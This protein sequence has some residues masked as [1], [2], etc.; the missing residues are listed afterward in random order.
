[1]MLIYTFIEYSYN[2]SKI[3]RSLYYRDDPA[4]NN[5]GNNDNFP[6]KGTSFK[7]K[8]NITGET[9]LKVIQKMLK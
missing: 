2:Y 4:L 5:D 1:M 7:F 3:S 9:L 6:G 8:V